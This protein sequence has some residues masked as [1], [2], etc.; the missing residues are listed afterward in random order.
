MSLPIYYYT[1]LLKEIELKYKFFTTF[2]S[3]VANIR[4]K[5]LKFN[6]F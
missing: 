4:C 2:T 5:N 3:P 1:I 6:S